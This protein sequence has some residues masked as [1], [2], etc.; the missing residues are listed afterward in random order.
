MR[1]ILISAVVLIAAAAFLGGCSRNC[2]PQYGPCTFHYPVDERCYY[3]FPNKKPAPPPC[4]IN[5]DP[6]PPRIVV[7]D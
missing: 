5:R 6:C 2:C 1:R 3:T 4:R 7:G